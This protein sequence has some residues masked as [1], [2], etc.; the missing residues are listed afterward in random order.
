MRRSVGASA[1][2]CV[3]AAP[4]LL[5]IGMATGCD[6]TASVPRAPIAPMSPPRDDGAPSQANGGGLEH[7]Q[8]LEELKIAPMSWVVDHQHSIRLL[9]PDAPHWLRVRIWTLKTLVTYRY[10]V[11]HHALVA[12]A[13]LHVPD[14][15]APEACTKAIEQRSQRW[16]DALDVALS[17]D[18]PRALVWND[19][20]VDV[21]SFV[22]AVA[23]IGDHEQYAAAY[24]T[25]PA[26]KGACLVLGV[27]VPAHGDLERAKAAR[28]R[29]SADMFP[30]VEVTSPTEPKDS[31]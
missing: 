22:A 29:L 15:N 21:D 5:C 4:C 7:A 25:Y 24:A 18:P 20:I 2:R 27:A 13:V 6:T 14:E 16:I 28:D 3:S 1:A 12:G 10:G 11:N 8:A 19:R 31:Y 23:T 30:S 17:H 9:L 26:W